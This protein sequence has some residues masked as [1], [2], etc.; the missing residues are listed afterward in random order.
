MYT[1]GCFSP[2]VATVLIALVGTF[3]IPDWPDTAKFLNEEERKLLNARLRADTEGVTMNR[4]DKKAAKRAFSD[5]KIYFGYDFF[6][7]PLP[8]PVYRK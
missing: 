5:P 8:T 4:L 6:L 7:L 3:I 1:Q 2:G